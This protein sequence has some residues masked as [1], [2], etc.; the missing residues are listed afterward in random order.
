MDITSY[1]PFAEKACEFLTASPDPF[2]SVQNNTVK[3]EA[4]GYVQLSK[5]HPFAGKLE[6]GGKYYYTFN[7]STLV[8]FAV[9]S[10]YKAGNGFKIIGGHTDSPNLKVKPHSK[11]SGSG[12][13]MLGVECYGGGLWHTWLDRDLGISGRVLVRAQSNGKEIIEQKFV[14]ISKPVARVSS[15]CIHLKTPEERK[16]LSLCKETH[17]APILGTAGILEQGARS[18]LTGGDQEDFWRKN[19]DPLLLELIANKLEI[20][21]K[22]I[23]DFELNLFDCQPASLGGLKEECL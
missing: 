3:L 15:L 4:A 7:K 23:A 2:H 20:E 17:L 11:K 10:K 12:C 9:G 6:P 13:V 16:S 1:I 8:A 19:Q 18:Q 21:V 22:Y 5:R 14:K